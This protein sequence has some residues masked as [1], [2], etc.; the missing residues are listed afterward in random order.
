MA[1]DGAVKDATKGVAKDVTKDV[2]KA[3]H[4]TG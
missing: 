4:A 2:V 3:A 1:C